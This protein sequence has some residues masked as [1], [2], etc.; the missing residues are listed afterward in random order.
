MGNA[1]E[2]LEYYVRLPYRTY[3][4]QDNCDGMPCFMAYNPELEGCMAQGPTPQEALANLKEAR[5]E[6]IAELL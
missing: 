2:N 5:S 4:M 6:Y 3:V 1:I